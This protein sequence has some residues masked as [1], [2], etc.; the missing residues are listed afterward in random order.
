VAD[1]DVQ[2]FL[3]MM[4]TNGIAQAHNAISFHSYCHTQHRPER[5]YFLNDFGAKHKALAKAH[6]G[7]DCW[8]VT[9]SGWST[10][11]AEGDEW[12]IIGIYPKA[13]YAGQAA[14]LVRMYLSAL[15][16][17]CEY[18]CMYDFMNDGTD[19]GNAEQNFGLVHADG[20]PKPS[21]A[22]VAALTRLVGQATFKAE[23]SE[24][25]DLY[26]VASFVR[27]TTPILVAWC[28]EGT[29]EW[30]L[31]EN[32][33]E[34]GKC[35]DLFGNETALPV[36]AGRR[37][38]L[39]E[40]PVYISYGPSVDGVAVRQDSATRLVTVEYTLGGASLAAVEVSVLTNG[41]P[42]G[43]EAL[44]A[45]HGVV[46]GVVTGG[47]QSVVWKPTHSWPGHV[48]TNHEVSAQVKVMSLNAMPDY[49]VFDLGI[50]SNIRY[51]ETTADFPVPL[52]DDCYRTRYIVMRR[53]PAAGVLWRMGTPASEF[54][55][56]GDWYKRNY[57]NTHYVTLTKD[58]YMAVYELTDY[59]YAFIDSGATTGSTKPKS[60]GYN[61][62]RG[63]GKKWPA[64][65][66]ELDGTGWFSKLRTH[67]GNVFA[68]DYPTE[69]QWEFACRAGT[70]TSWPNGKDIA[71]GAGDYA[72]PNLA[73]IAWYAKNADNA[74][75]I[76][77]LKA[78]NA[79]GLYDMIGNVAEVCLDNVGGSSFSPYETEPATDP[80]GSATVSDKIVTRS[81][82]HWDAQYTFSSGRRGSQSRTAGAGNAYN[83][84]R[85]CVTLP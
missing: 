76:V 9:E 51:Y 36:V 40:R 41:V 81:G 13:S 17:G 26:R 85:L 10:F 62:M 59:Q 4:I 44:A 47:Y 80:K 75:H 52:G 68:F 72:D 45:T 31:P 23:L 69:A 60:I 38:R 30:E 57:E 58:Y 29:C 34:P 78:P 39:T 18:A 48:F 64:D 16:A 70:P 35:Y 11:E 5:E 21:F 28:V 43:A 84:I 20:T 55:T 6:G 22:A 33:G 73:Q 65:G 56:I 71:N 3:D 32:L 83:G 27:G 49:L 8:C 7:A 74:T 46:S 25:P 79:Y 24:V 61:L 2:Y 54:A 50:P 77:G 66:H 63:T 12:D 19:A 42:I 37:I 1:E 14:C 15:E 53:I 82:T 67:F